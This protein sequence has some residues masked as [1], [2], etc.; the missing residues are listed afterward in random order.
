MSVLML[1][2]EI[3]MTVYDMEKTC[4]HQDHDFDEDIPEE[5]FQRLMRARGLA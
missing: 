1:L 4:V 3:T 2:Y 5:E